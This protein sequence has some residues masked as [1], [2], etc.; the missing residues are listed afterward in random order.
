MPPRLKRL[1]LQH[2]GARLLA[3]ELPASPLTRAALGALA[4]C[5][6][7][8]SIGLA[9]YLG[10]ERV[11]L[12]RRTRLP[13][14]TLSIGNLTVGGTG[15]TP[16]TQ[17]LCRTLASEGRRAAV[18]SRGHG[19]A[20]QTVRVVSDAHGTVLMQASEAGDEPL[21]LARTLP[22]TPVVVGK[23]RRA[24]GRAALARFAPDALVLDDGFQYWQLA[25]D[26]D[27][28]LLD[29]RR[30]FDNG[31]PLPRGLLR[32]PKR[33]LGRAQTVVVTRAQD[34]D[35]AGR[36]AL[37]REIARLAP[38]AE[39]YWARHAAQGFVPAA[40]L[41]GPLLPLDALRGQTIVALS[42]IAQ[43]ASFAR[44]L[45]QDAGVHIARH[46]VFAD[47]AR[48][49]SQDVLEAQAAVE[50]APASALVMTEK[51]AVKWPAEPALPVPVYA[52]RTAMQVEDHA[53]WAASIMR[54]LFGQP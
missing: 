24:S 3:G 52:L 18:L 53:R 42:G 34:L 17:L 37:R 29:A 39:L 14:P 40:D 9:A 27:M 6:V 31:W 43:P 23:D 25:R 5:A 47:H 32:E 13:V 33:H 15:K 12:R 51:D 8:Y 35:D 11:G 10:M 44:A 20:G 26:L 41:G 45:T 16:M 30:P 38:Q 21:L 4:G 50:A 2:W 22:G 36:E 49:G 28:V 1:H 19:G 7:L 46:I 54:C 48:Y